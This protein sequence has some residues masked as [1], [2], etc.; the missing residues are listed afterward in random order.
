MT[1]LG[2]TAQ[3]SKQNVNVKIPLVKQ[4]GIASE[5]SKQLELKGKVYKLM[6]QIDKIRAK[7][8]PKCKK[9]VLLASSRREKLGKIK[10]ILDEQS[11]DRPQEDV[12]VR[13]DP[14]HVGVQW[15]C[16]ERKSNNKNRCPLCQEHVDSLLALFTHHETKHFVCQ[17][18]DTPFVSQAAC[19]RHEALHQGTDALLVYKCHLCEQS[20]DCTKNLKVHVK[21]SHWEIVDVG[22]K[23]GSEEVKVIIERLVYE[24]R[25]CRIS[26]KD[27][28]NY[29]NHMVLHQ[30]NV[31][32]PLL[33]PPEKI[34]D[35]HLSDQR[36]LKLTCTICTQT[37]D[38]PDA[39]ETHICSSFKPEELFKICSIFCTHI[40]I[41]ES[42]CDQLLRWV[43]K[44]INEFVECSRA[45][46]REDTMRTSCIC[47]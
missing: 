13:T 33:Q 17:L 30:M 34:S 2:G 26:V 3:I 6:I 47:C 40:L 7:P 18:C 39:A 27:D 41:E 29:R 45:N 31:A 4:N 20:Y 37:F 24:C 36:N 1:P 15:Q 44:M 14:E 19:D 9:P 16:S 10:E 38:T 25:I 12:G 43:P 8:G 23:V 21:K 35:M 32:K 22:W 46:F 42:E 5:Y 11:G 28:E